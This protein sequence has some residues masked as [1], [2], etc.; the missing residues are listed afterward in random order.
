MSEDILVKNLKQQLDRLFN[1]LAD[2]EEC[3]SV[4]KA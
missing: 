2:L 1:Q 3:R 4:F